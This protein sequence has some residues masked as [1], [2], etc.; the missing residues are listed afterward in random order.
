MGI[1]NRNSKKFQKSDSSNSSGTRN[2]IDNNRGGESSPRN[3]KF[4]VS[5]NSR[6]RAKG[7]KTSINN[8]QNKHSTNRT[9]KR[10]N[11]F[12]NDNITSRNNNTKN[13][14][15][16]INTSQNKN[17]GKSSKNLQGKNHSSNNQ[18]NNQRKRSKAPLE[19]MRIMPL[20]GDRKSVV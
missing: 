11:R 14:D 8:R 19:T 1:E 16:K 17:L 4:K 15:T 12:S 2:K 3:S 13:T 5:D 6:S 18:K 10:N 7:V 9:Q 20:G